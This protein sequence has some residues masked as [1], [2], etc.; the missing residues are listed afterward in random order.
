MFC[1]R[2]NRS[3]NDSHR[4]SRAISALACADRSPL[5]RRGLTPAKHD[6][7]ASKSGSG[8]QIVPIGGAIAAALASVT[9]CLVAIP[10]Y[11]QDHVNRPVKKQWRIA[12]AQHAPPQ[13]TGSDFGDQQQT[14][15]GGH[16]RQVGHE[17]FATT[18]VASGLPITDD[19]HHDLDLE[20]PWFE[21]D[22]SPSCDS[23]PSGVAG[24]FA[25]RACNNWISVDYLRWKTSGGD[26]PPLVRTSPDG[27]PPEQTAVIGLAG[28]TLVGGDSGDFTQSG[29][30][31]GGGWWLDDCHTRGFEL[32][33]A[34]LPRRR[35]SERLD[36]QSFPHLGRPVIDTGTEAA[37]LIAHPSFLTGQ[38]GVDR[39]SAFHHVEALRRDMLI[40]NPCRRIDSL[41]GLRYASLEDS[42]LISQ[43]STY[44]VAQGQIL[45]GTERN[46]FDRFEASN[47]FQGF[48]LGLDYTEHIGVLSLHA[49]GTLGLGNNRTEGVIGGQ[50]TVTV[51]G[52]P[53]GPA[54]F[55]GGLLAQTTNIGTFRRNRFNLMP[56]AYVGISAKLR[57]GWELKAGYQMIYWSDAIDTA[58]QV[59]LNVSQFPPEPP[60]GN[61][62][63]VLTSGGG[64]FIHGLQTGLTL[65]F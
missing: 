14:T 3:Q 27:T 40:S 43:S 5:K 62:P 7:Q 51:P 18:P 57:Y 49:R 1:Y 54:T 20:Q 52:D 58:S 23:G 47:R 17:S 35:N 50:T 63:G 46:L 31:I 38:V 11:S 45:P 61:S 53:D 41:I 30:R 26:L 24:M 59:D 36:S 6:S 13:G 32:V 44:T 9:F 4:P 42:L 39:S 21:G 64:V 8:L 29:F 65:T 25:N 48:V 12:S 60:A 37:M 10:A 22:F 2:L 15:D 34:G 33:Y 19:I 56:E 55:A 28:T 16:L